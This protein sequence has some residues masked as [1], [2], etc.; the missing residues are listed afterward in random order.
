MDFPEDIM[1]MIKKYIFPIEK[2]LPYVDENLRILF[3]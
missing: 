2:K 1:Q 3:I